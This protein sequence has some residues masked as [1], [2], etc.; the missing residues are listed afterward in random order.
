MI[1]RPEKVLVVSVHL[2]FPH[3]FN[4]PE[5]DVNV[6]VRSKDALMFHYRHLPFITDSDLKKT[7]R[8]VTMHRFADVIERRVSSATE[9]N[10]PRS[11]V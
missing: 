7:V 2:I 11:T 1:L 4:D 10:R 3:N 9:I 8:D 6:D 5:H